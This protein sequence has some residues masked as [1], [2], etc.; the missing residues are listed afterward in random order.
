MAAALSL[1]TQIYQPF[2]SGFLNQI[3]S[4]HTGETVLISGHSNTVPALVNQLVG[5]NVLEELGESVYSKIF[6]VSLQRIGDGR[7]TVLNF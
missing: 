6:M 1:E 4:K 3:L 2:Q 5:D 7:I